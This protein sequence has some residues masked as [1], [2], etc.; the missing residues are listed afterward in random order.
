MKECC[1][2]AVNRVEIRTEREDVTIHQCV[3]C[4]RKHYR[5]RVEPG[6][7]GAL[8]TKAGE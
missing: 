2:S 1:Q 8:F 5:L 4:G 3:A 6:R 7:L